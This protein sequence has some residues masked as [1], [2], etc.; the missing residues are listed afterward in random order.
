M[1]FKTQKKGIITSLFS[2]NSGYRPSTH[3]GV[4]WYIGYGK[5]VTTD[6]AGVV[7]H[8]DT[9]GSDGWRAVWI[10][11]PHEDYLMEVCL[12][13]LKDIFVEVGE[14]V[15]EDQ[16]IGTEGNFG[17]VYSN[18]VQVTPAMRKAGSKAGSHVHEQYRPVQL[19]DRKTRKK[20]YRPYKNNG[21]HVEVLI[22]NNRKGCIDPL[23]FEV[24][25]TDA[26]KKALKKSFDKAV[27]N[28]NPQNISVVKKLFE[29]FKALLIKSK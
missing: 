19:V 15:D 9:N 28:P 25:E 21:K 12:G 13:H 17:L 7:A 11:V 23:E 27:A 2:D 1:K 8:I 16:V 29:A 4:D 14:W 18:G 10:L 24:V 26:L 3:T 5:P 20:H 6:N 22:E